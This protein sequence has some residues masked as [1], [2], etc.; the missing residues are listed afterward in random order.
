MKWDKGTSPS[1]DMC[2]EYTKTMYEDGR[3]GYLVQ[4]D[5]ETAFFGGMI[6]SFLTMRRIVSEDI[7][8]NETKRIINNFK[9]DILSAAHDAEN[10]KENWEE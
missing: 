9:R 8:D 5:L 1:M 4:K 10:R 6:A 7:T 3:T 2:E